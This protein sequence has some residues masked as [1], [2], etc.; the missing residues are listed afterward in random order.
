MQI[1]LLH[2]NLLTCHSILIN[3][4]YNFKLQ[5]MIFFI[6]VATLFVEQNSK[7]FVIFVLPRV[8]NMGNLG[9]LFAKA[10]INVVI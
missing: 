6:V 1:G 10:C 4:Y 7:F 2:A 8:F 9:K 3:C 5:E